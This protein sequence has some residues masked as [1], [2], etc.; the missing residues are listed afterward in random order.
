M[1]LREGKN[2]TNGVRFHLLAPLLLKVNTLLVSCF[3]IVF[4][5]CGG[6]MG[7]DNEAPPST[8]RPC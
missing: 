3:S 7:R 6:D 1:L 8:L 5:F 4:V 2:A